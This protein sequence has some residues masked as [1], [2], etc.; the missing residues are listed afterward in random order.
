MRR[1][2]IL[3]AS[4]HGK[5]VAEAALASGWD[6]IV[7]FDDAWPNLSRSGIWQVI[8]NS[9]L[10][11]KKR[12]SFDGVVIAIGDNK[13]REQKGRILDEQG[14]SLESVIH[15]SAVVSESAVLGKGTV[16]LANATI[17]AGASI[18]SGS[19]INTG[20]VVEHDCH[21]GDC[22]HVSPNAV[23]A[24]GVRVG[25]RSWVGAN[26]SVRQMV[27]LGADVVVGMGSVVLENVEPG[28]TVVGVPCRPLS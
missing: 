7:F 28:Q 12:Q 2:A 1:L 8:G 22:V 16:V 9:D 19:I 14:L 13:V 23:L 6:E 25:S 20:A 5:V 21:L 3:G 17:N 11:I 24:G 18:G 27:I 4:G 10:I 26:S 15:P